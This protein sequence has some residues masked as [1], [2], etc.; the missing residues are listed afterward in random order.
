MSVFRWYESLSSCWYCVSVSLS[1]KL[2]LFSIVEI[3]NTVI[4]EAFSQLTRLI[5]EVFNNSGRNET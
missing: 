3:E 2:F 4:L 1:R 5:T